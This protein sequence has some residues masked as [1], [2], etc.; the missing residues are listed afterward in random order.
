MVT[1][2]GAFAFFNASVN[3]R[4]KFPAPAGRPDHV[5][6]QLLIPGYNVDPPV[7]DRSITLL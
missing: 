1:I 6:Q 4:H 5:R 3:A 2:A 7:M